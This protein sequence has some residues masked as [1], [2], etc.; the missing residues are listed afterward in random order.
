MLSQQLAYLIQKIKKLFNPATA[1]SQPNTPPRRPPQQYGKRRRPVK[2]I[3][4]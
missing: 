2:K 3:Q 1:K 4:I